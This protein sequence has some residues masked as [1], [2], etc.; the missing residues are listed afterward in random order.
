M[1]E[2]K[3]FISAI[4]QIAEE[5]GILR[6]KVVEIIEMALSAAYKKD[7]GKRGQIIRADFDQKIGEMKFFQLKL[8]VDESVL[9]EDVSDDAEVGDNEDSK[10]KRTN[11]EDLLKQEDKKLNGEIE[12][13][14]KSS[15][16]NAIEDDGKKI[17]FNIEK[18][19]M[20]E[21]AKEALR[22][23]GAVLV[24]RAPELDV[25]EDKIK[26]L[27][28]A[29]REVG[30]KAAK[31]IEL[32]DYIETPLEGKDSYGRI[33]AQTA[34]QVIMQRVREAERD[35]VYTEFKSKEGEVVSG[36]IQRMEGGS[37]FVDIGKTTGTIFFNEQIPRE[38]Y[39]IGQRIR[40][41]V[42]KV[43]H[44]ARG[45]LVMLSR[46]HPKMVIKLFEFEVPEIGGGS[47]EIKAIAREAGSRSKVAVVSHAE[48]VDPVGSCVGQKG[49]RVSTII[50]E[51]GGEKIDIIEWNDDEAKFIANA[52]A[53]A[54]ILN[55][56]LSGN[57]REAKVEVDED[58]LSLAI[59]KNGQNVR[60]A[61]KLTGWRIDIIAGGKTVENSEKNLEKSETDEKSPK[62]IT[63]K[64]ETENKKEPGEDKIDDKKEE[65]KKLKKVKKAKKTEEEKKE[66]GVNKDKKEEK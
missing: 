34:K 57:M 2:Q 20:I 9:K 32:F 52:L 13:L 44:D 26:L 16:E 50:N 46:A 4:A 24:K 58:Q 3:Q 42:I 15:D 5:K 37:I 27:K 66:D 36:I 10:L 45:S 60:L 41:Y 18:H 33:A 51:L 55:V 43:D 28:E 64:E 53:P 31:K 59:G 49:T 11:N 30:A 48:G 14:T 1:L 7:Y 17:K 25:V 39:Q 22:K 65:K 29:N 47:V 8:V 62:E 23:E 21:D 38:R 61:A 19:I 35:V 12:I 56:K 40:A 6:E 54:K 63:A